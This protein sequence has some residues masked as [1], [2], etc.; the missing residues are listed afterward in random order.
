MAFGDIGETIYLQEDPN[1]S[2]AALV[3]LGLA[4]GEGPAAAEGRFPDEMD[5][6]LTGDEEDFPEEEKEEE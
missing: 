2:V 6:P 4:V 3:R 1:F 5:I